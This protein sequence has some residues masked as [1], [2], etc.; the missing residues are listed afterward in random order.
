MGQSNQVHQLKLLLEITLMKNSQ[1][2][3]DMSKSKDAIRVRLIIYVWLK[4]LIFLSFW[5]ELCK[6]LAVMLKSVRP[7]DLTDKISFGLTKNKYFCYIFYCSD[8]QNFQN[9]SKWLA[10][11]KRFQ[12]LC[13]WKWWTRDQNIDSYVEISFLGKIRNFKRKRKWNFEKFWF[14]LEMV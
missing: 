12:H 10:C 8:W 1:F 9:Q 4:C 3:E 6:T 13:S 5:F 2:C 7:K 11:P 14:L